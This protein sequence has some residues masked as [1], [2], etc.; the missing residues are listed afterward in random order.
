MNE[1]IIQVKNLSKCYS[2]SHQ[3][4]YQT[5]R[6]TVVE[7]VKKPFRLL[8]GKTKKENL[9]ALKDINFEVQKGEAIGLIG[10]NGSGKSTLLKI[11]SQIT[12]PTT[13]EIKI[14]GQVASL[15]EIGTGF[16]PELTGRENIFLNGAILGMSKKEIIS[17]FN[18]IVKFSGVEKF[19]DT[20]VKR[21]SSGMHVRLAFSVA[22]HMD[23][24]ILIVD[25]VLAVGDA[26]FQKKCLGKMD[27]VT[28]EAGRTIIFVSHNMEAIKKLCT[29]CILLKEGNIVMFDITEKVIEKYLKKNIPSSNISLINRRDRSG[30]QG[31][32]FTEI[33]I[34]NLQH[35]KEIKS[36][37][38]LR[39]TLKYDSPF[40]E[41]I[42]GTRVAIT[43]INE[44]LQPVL[45]FDSEICSETL[46]S[47]MDPQGEVIC[48]TGKVH[49][50]P[51]RYFANIDFLIGGVTS[52]S[53]IMASEFHIKTN[54]QDYNYNMMSDKNVNNYLIKYSFKQ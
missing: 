29:K 46:N 17:K 15:L 45:M 41:K 12:A 39:I 2:I 14:R 11:L 27:E 21:Y 18:D 48:E 53:L 4:P 44:D 16:H 6:D 3:L 22:A 50:F 52:D 38:G 32:K 9:W 30:K 51:G 19:L 36:G 34:T 24:D 23:P 49:L 54:I 33:N 43:I 5:L 1:P 37:D 7:L 31:V 40:T 35:S 8:R 28:K 20:P 13:G 10:A 26:D 47:N 42:F 25:E